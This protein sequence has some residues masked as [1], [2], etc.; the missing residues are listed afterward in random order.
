[1]SAYLKPYIITNE[2]GQRLLKMVGGFSSENIKAAEQLDYEI[3]YLSD[4]DWMD[5][6]GIKNL[7]HQI[8]GI[9]IKTY[10]D[11]NMEPLSFFKNLKFLKIDVLKQKINGRLIFNEFIKL[12]DCSLFWNKNFDKNLFKLPSLERLMLISFD[13]NFKELSGLKNLKYLYINGGKFSDIEGM[14]NLDSLADLHI[15]SMPK[16]TDLSPVSERHL[17][18][19]ALKIEKC[20]NIHDFSFLAE[21]HALQS[22]SVGN[23]IDLTHIYKMKSLQKLIAYNPKPLDLFQVLSLQ[24]IEK[25]EFIQA[26]N[27]DYT[28]EE[29]EKYSN[30]IGLIVKAFINGQGNKKNVFIEII[31]RNFNN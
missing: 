15:L 13:G 2:F 20:P 3:L 27:F 18:L 21:M 4:G 23:S 1:M 16:L 11:C 26:R 12:E 19:Q 9:Y 14:K 17:S 6:G 29:I 10:G 31:S 25:I 28:I 22:L 30:S 5:F 8:S 7:Y 24:K